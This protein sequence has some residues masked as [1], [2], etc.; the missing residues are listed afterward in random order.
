MLILHGIY[1][2]AVRGVAFRHDFCRGCGQATLAVRVRA[3]RVVHLYWV[4]VLPLELAHLALQPLRA[5]TGRQHQDTARI[6]HRRCRDAGGPGHR[7]LV[8]SPGRGSRRG[9]CLRLVGEDRVTAAAALALRAAWR[10]QPDADRQKALAGIQPFTG[11]DCPA[12]GGQLLGRPT[13]TASAAGAATSPL[14]A[15]GQAAEYPSQ[16]ARDLYKSFGCMDL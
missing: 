3:F 8:G 14:A 2:W 15:S 11:S 16:G 12:C 6:Q 13:A 9:A 10:H 1:Q 5:A 4:P 7:R